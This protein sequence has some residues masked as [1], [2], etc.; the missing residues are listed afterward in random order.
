MITA[1][2][3]N[4]ETGLPGDKFLPEG[5]EGLSAEEEY[6]KAFE[7]HRDEVFAYQGWDDLL[8]ELGLTAITKT[9][10]DLNKEGRAYSELIARRGGRGEGNIHRQLKEY[11][12]ETPAVLDLDAKEPGQKEFLFVSGDRCDVVFDSGEDGV[13]IVEVKDGAH[14]G[15]L[16]RGVYQAVKYRSLMVAEK[17]Q[18]EAYSVRAF[19]AAQKMPDY[20]RQLGSRFDIDC[21]QVSLP[22]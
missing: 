19:L 13:V 11:I 8:K 15:E 5:T 16:V 3:V 18:G 21:R 14:D 10:D 7:A 20:V 1:I 12:A 17:G 6:E 22:E 2:V 4:G 9:L